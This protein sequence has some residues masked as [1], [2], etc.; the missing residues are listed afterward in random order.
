MPERH[1]VYDSEYFC[2]NNEDVERW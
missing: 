2:I 1:N